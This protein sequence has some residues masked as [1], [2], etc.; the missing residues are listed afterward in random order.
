MNKYLL[1]YEFKSMLKDYYVLGFGLLLPIFFAI[2]LPLSITS[3]VPKAFVNDVL[4]S[5]VVAQS[6]LIILS[7]LLVSF[8]VTCALEFKMDIP[9][10]LVYFDIDYK[11]QIVAK[12]IVHYTVI[13]L[14]II[15]YFIVTLTYHNTRIE[16]Y[17]GFMI[18][19]SLLLLEGIGALLIAYGVALLSNNF[20]ITY[21]VSL[22]LFFIIMFVSGSMGVTYDNM[23]KAFQTFDDIFIPFATVSRDANKIW[24][25]NSFDIT[26]FMMSWA[27][28]TLIGL[29]LTVIAIRKRRVV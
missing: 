20:G 9:K 5:F 17:K 6:Q 1:K 7:V 4:N 28:F 16:S 27:A 15:I 14:F 22:G 24:S 21:T 11:K 8:G 18:L 3:S 25:G 10:R 26:T 29:I 2:L 12:I 19:V 13:V 23:P